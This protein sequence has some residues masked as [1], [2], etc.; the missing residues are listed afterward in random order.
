MWLLSKWFLNSLREDVTHGLYL[1]LALGFW[2][3]R[4]QNKRMGGGDP[5][6]EK[7]AKHKSL[8]QQACSLKQTGQLR[9]PPQVTLDFLCWGLWV[10]VVRDRA[11]FTWK[12]KI[13]LASWH[14][15]AIL[16]TSHLGKTKPPIFLSH[17]HF[18]VALNSPK[19]KPKEWED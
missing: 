7:H 5:W 3:G 12:R 6:F 4:K 11:T 19:H 8:N 10:K 2:S 1:C 9:S 15:S 17:S 13:L 18:P 14:S 16:Y